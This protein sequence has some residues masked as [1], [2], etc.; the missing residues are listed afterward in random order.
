[1]MDHMTLSQSQHGTIDIV[2]EDGYDSYGSISGEAISQTQLHIRPCQRVYIT[3][4]ASI[5]H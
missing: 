5:L 2:R 4:Y 3:L 1:M